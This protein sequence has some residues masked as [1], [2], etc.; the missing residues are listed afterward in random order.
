MEKRFKIETYKT[1]EILQDFILFTYRV[2]NPGGT[3]KMVVLSAGL[4]V[5]GYLAAMEKPQVGIVFYLLGGAALLFSVF[6]H[7]IALVQLKKADVAYKEQTKLGYEFTNSG[8]YVYKNDVLDENVGGYSHVTCLYGDEKNYYVG[9][10]NEDL[11]LLPRKD[12]VEGDEAEFT[13]FIEKKSNEKYEFVPA[14]LKN[15][16]MM[17]RMGVKQAQMEHDAKAAELR[18]GKSKK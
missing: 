4:L 2:K 3:M 11:F 16:W 9:I 17:H 5:I 15:K 7:K 10:N 14:T 12:F 13:A 1:P 8:I 18:K 6:K